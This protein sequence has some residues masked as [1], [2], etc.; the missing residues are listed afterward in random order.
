MHMTTLILNIK[1]QYT[2]LCNTKGP[3]LSSEKCTVMHYLFR[4]EITFDE[5]SRDVNNVLCK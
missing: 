3:F 4:I 1:V 2:K 5:Y